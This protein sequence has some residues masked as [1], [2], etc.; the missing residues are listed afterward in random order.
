MVSPPATKST[1]FHVR[2]A[3]LRASRAAFTPYST[4]FRPHLPQG[5]IPTPRIATSFD[6]VISSARR[7]R[8][9]PLPDHHALFVGLEERVE[10]ELHLLAHGEVRVIE[11]LRDHPH[12]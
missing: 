5:C 6:I 11:G 3:S 10:H 4:K 2:P 7:L 12:H 9:A 8:G 1:S